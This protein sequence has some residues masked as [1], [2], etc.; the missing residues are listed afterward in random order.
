HP[1][2]QTATLIRGSA[3]DASTAH[4]P[5]Q[6]DF[7][8]EW[9]NFRENPRPGATVLLRL[10]ESTYKPG[11]GA[12]GDDHPISWKREVG[13]GRAWYT[14]LGHRPET[15]ADARF[16]GHLAGGVDWVLDDATVFADGFE[17]AP[18]SGVR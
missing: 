11:D 6:F 5:A 15:Y 3:G 10:D 16:V 2:I 9:Y 4:L 13:L 8:D 1:A 17:S 14:G 7:T 12:M 18:A